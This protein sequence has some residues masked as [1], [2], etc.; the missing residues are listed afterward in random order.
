MS[1]I[2]DV[3]ELAGLSVATVSRYL[4]NSG[5]VSENARKKISLAI[6]TL[7]YTPNEVARS[8]YNKTS[9]LIGLLVPQI[10]N[11]YFSNIIKGVESV[12]N[13]RGFHLIVSNVD[14]L[15]DEKKYME[16]FMTNNIA[17]IISSTGFLDDQSNIINCPIVGVDRAIDNFEHAVF[18]DEENGGKLSA[19]AIINSGCKNVLVGSGPKDLEIAEK[20]LK[21]ALSILDKHSINY[22]IHYSKGYDYE[23]A[24]EFVEF[25]KSSSTNYDSIIA[26]SDLH[27]LTCSLY[28]NKIGACIPDDVQIVGYDDTIFSKLSNPN[29]STINHDGDLLGEKAAEM[30]IDLIEGKE[31]ENNKVQLF[32]KLI[33][34]DSL[35]KNSNR[36]NLSL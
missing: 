10:D 26:S 24:K 14:N 29:I 8:L 30:L 18:Y 35:R 5:Y 6:K 22:D 21:G 11:P 36:E 1:T 9:K 28:L 2:K 13:K 27:A 4:N 19:Q 15:R 12:C 32:S 7:N 25:L 34:K 3:A 31:L 17:G 23:S 20:R 33:E 16:S